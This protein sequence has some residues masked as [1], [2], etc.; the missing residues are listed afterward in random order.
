MA[1][2][3]SIQNIDAT[4]QIVLGSVDS[5]N[6]V[7]AYRRALRDFRQW[8]IKHGRGELSKAIVQAY[9]LELKEK[10]MNAGNINLR[11][12]AIR[13]LAAEAAD[14]GM[15]DPLVVSGILRIKGMRA[16]GKRLGNWLT[17]IQAQELLNTVDI[18]TLRGK[19]DKAILAVLLGCGLR[20]EEA[21][22]LTFKHIQQRDNRWVIVDL[23]G[24]RN[25]LRSIPMPDWCKEIID[26][27][28]EA[29]WIKSGCVFRRI[30]RGDHIASK[31]M[32][33]QAI[34]TAVAE[35]SHRLG[36]NNLAPHDCRRTFAKLAHKGG[37]PI[38][39]IQYSLGHASIRTTEIYL[40]IEQ[41]LV[42]A[43]C[44]HLGLAVTSI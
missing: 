30:R 31:T 25:S 8:Y 20:R 43:P 1:K 40:G 24:K 32:A 37:S 44:D 23:V 29:A 2:N 21:A 4:I 5:I 38:E 13:R 33:S 6:T 35:Y 19:R 28:A 26:Q 41:N 27:W 34:Y 22:G 7:R 42:D 18:S 3:L 39:Q 16:E 11:L 14:N 9:A 15:L 12:I 10:G 17:K 36:L